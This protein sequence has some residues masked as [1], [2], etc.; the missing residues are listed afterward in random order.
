MKKKG[1]F[2]QLLPWFCVEHFILLWP[3]DKGQCGQDN[4]SVEGPTVDLIIMLVSK[5]ITEDPNTFHSTFQMNK[6]AC[7]WAA[8]ESYSLRLVK[9]NQIMSRL[10]FLS[11]VFTP[12]THFHTYV[13]VASPYNTETGSCFR[14]FHQQYHTTS[15]GTLAQLHSLASLPDTLACQHGWP[16]V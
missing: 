11:H 13:H 3:Q 5:P 16:F 9:G 1:L 14:I 7:R 15:S 12:R 8:S 10:V 4:R 2:W 6:V